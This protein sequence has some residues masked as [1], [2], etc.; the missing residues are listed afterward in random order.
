MLRDDHDMP[1]LTFSVRRVIELLVFFYLW[2]KRLSKRPNLLITWTCEVGYQDIGGGTSRSLR[3]AIV[4]AY[5]LTPMKQ[6]LRKLWMQGDPLSGHRLHI[7]LSGEE[8]PS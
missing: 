5:E 6:H 2:P 1:L 7:E 3:A 4:N 8:N